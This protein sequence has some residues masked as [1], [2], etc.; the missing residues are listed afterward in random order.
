MRIKQSNMGNGNNTTFFIKG[1][2]LSDNLTIK[3]INYCLIFMIS[4]KKWIDIIWL[5]VASGGMHVRLYSTF[6]LIIII[7]V[8]IWEHSYYI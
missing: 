2:T 8:K 4:Q 7:W 6:F 3:Q 1:Y 5:I